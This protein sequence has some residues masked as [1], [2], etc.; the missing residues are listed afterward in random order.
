MSACWGSRV[1]GGAPALLG[2]AVSLIGVM[3]ASGASGEARRVDRVSV[4]PGGVVVERSGDSDTVHIHVNDKGHE[5]YGEGGWI[6][7]D[8]DGDALVRVFGDIHVPKGKRISDDVVAVFGSVEVDGE[9]E[10]DVVAVMGSVRL[11]D[12]A[13]VQGEVVS[14]GGVVDQDDGSS[15]HGQTVSVGFFPVSWGLPALPLTLS[16]IAAGWVAAVFAGWLFAIAFPLQ[17]LRVAATASRRTG[18][19]LAMGLVSVPGFVALVMLMFVTVVGIPIAFLLP[20]VYIVLIYAGQLAATYLLGCKLIGRTPGSP[21]LVWPIVAG[22][23]LVSAF[24]VVGAILFVVPGM[25]RPLALFSALLGIL[26]ATGLTAIGTGAF[27][28]S[29]FGTQPKDPQWGSQAATPIAPP[30]TAPPTSA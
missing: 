10:G 11:N 28:L 3:A 27:L 7:V 18:A 24:F 5:R 23:L 8:D 15:I 17:L 26:V 13:V 21:G 19:S 29:K 6:E 20:L 4:G 16:A 12:G 22:T 2:L 9:V 1:R 25:T 30:L 14:V